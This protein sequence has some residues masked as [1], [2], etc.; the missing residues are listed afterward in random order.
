VLT[1][2]RYPSLNNKSILEITEVQQMELGP[3]TD[4]PVATPNDEWDI[5]C[6]KPWTQP[7]SQRMRPLGAVPRWYEAAVVSSEAEALFRENEIMEM[8]EKA[9]WTPDELKARGILAAVYG[10]ALHMLREMDHVGRSDSN[11]LSNTFGKLLKKGNNPSR[12]IPGL[13]PNS[14]PRTVPGMTSPSPSRGRSRRRKGDSGAPKP[15]SESS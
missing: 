4:L 7:T 10:P 8:G 9:K 5:R 15:Q 12:T 11:G 13:M 1:K 14:A 6:A 3:C 2:W